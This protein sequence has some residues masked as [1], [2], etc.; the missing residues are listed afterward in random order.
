MPWSSRGK[1]PAARIAGLLGDALALAVLA[2]ALWK[3]LA[4]PRSFVNAAA[5]Q[6]APHARFDRLDG[7]T[8]RVASLRGRLAFL[9]FY[10]SWCTPCRIELPLV[11]RWAAAHPAVA[12][13]YIDVAEP[14]AVAA[15]FARRYGLGDV[16]LDPRGDARGIFSIEGFPTIVVVDPQG[17][18]RAKWEGLNPAISLAMSNARTRLGHAR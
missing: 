7:G 1:L 16:S 5:A 4:A 6:P 14:P 3:F 17:R 10:A 9:D 12:V 2:F 11:K 8:L 18:I 15:A 13:V